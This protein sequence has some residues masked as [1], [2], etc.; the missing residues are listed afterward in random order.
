MPDEVFQFNIV[1][2]A[3]AAFST[4]SENELWCVTAFLYDNKLRVDVRT[5]A[6]ELHEDTYVRPLSNTL[7]SLQST[8]WPTRGDDPVKGSTI[9]P[10][11][12]ISSISFRGDRTYEILGR[13]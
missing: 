11:A 1:E 6:G 5:S 12:H 13:P 10:L 7:A 8:V 4:K 9:V 3:K 2:L